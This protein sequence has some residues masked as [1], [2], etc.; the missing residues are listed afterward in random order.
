MKQ[1]QI[2]D[3]LDYISPQRAIMALKVRVNILIRLS[4][5][6]LKDIQH[7]SERISNSVCPQR[8]FLRQIT[9]PANFEEILKNTNKGKASEGEGLK[10]ICV[11][12]SRTGTSSLKAALS[13][14][15]PGRTYHAMEFLNEINT[16]V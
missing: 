11:G 5:T 10:V 15:L 16:E 13:I 1:K 6:I 8:W 2:S 9:V 12:L 4:V 3:G 14:L 7:R